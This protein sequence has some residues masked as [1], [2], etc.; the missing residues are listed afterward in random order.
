MHFSIMK[1]N[2]KVSL[3]WGLKRRKG[4]REVCDFF[5]YLGSW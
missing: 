4:E 2:F 5:P 1:E 3:D